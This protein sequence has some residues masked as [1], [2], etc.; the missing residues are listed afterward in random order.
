MQDNRNHNNV[1]QNRMDIGNNVINI[2][3]ERR[4][5]ENQ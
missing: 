4:M 1:Q 2:N 3:L 5:D